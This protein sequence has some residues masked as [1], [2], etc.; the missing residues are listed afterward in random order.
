VDFFEFYL[1]FDW[2]R[3]AASIR[4]ALKCGVDAEGRRKLPDKF[5]GLHNRVAREVWY[6]EDPFDLGHNLS[7]KC[8]TAGR[9]RIYD[10]LRQTYESIKGSQGR[11]VL[12][13]FDEACPKLKGYHGADGQVDGNP[14]QNRTYLLKCR[15][16][17]KKVTPQAFAQ[18]FSEYSVDS[19]HFP[20]QSSQATPD[21]LQE[22][23]M[24]FPTD[25]DRKQAHTLNETYMNGWQ[26]RLF[27]T[28]Q[29]CLDDAKAAGAQFETIPGWEGS[30][31]K[32]TDAQGKSA[33]NKASGWKAAAK[34][35]VALQS[36]RVIDGVGQAEG[37]DELNVLMQRAQALN[38]TREVKLCEEKLG[39]MRKTRSG[40]GS[41]RVGG[42]SSDSPRVGPWP[43][44]PSTGAGSGPGA[45][46]GGV[47][48]A[49]ATG[50]Q[51][52]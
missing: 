41:S 36:K 14:G 45:G 29:H 22:A 15:L 20:L 9:R 27:T 16:N 49:Q 46:A 1:G 23:F 52:Q 37:F 26:L 30:L 24:I 10:S 7:A 6:V 51:F 31:K 17:Q 25:D 34:S 12:Q 19:M 11:N 39:D 42:R 40:S 8:T 38:L 43:S 32:E 35:E 4:L 18:A 47:A 44:P 5:H 21:V 50:V 3:H 13:A 33:S 48:K 2:D 28:T